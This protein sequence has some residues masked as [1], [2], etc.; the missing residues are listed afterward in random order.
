MLHTV[1]LIHTLA[2]AFVIQVQS[3][4]WAI[5]TLLSFHFDNTFLIIHSMRVHKA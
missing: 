3:V 2:L 5:H 1:Y 4:R